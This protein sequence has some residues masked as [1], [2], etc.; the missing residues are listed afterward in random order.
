M[1]GNTEPAGEAA[2]PKNRVFY[3][4]TRRNLAVQKVGFP[5]CPWPYEPRS[6]NPRNGL[7]LLCEVAV[8]THFIKRG[9]MVRMDQIIAT[10]PGCLGLGLE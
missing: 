6:R 7:Q 10:N 3:V 2:Y 4:P 5:P 1:S 9:R 8:D